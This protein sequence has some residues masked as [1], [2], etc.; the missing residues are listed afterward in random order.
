MQNEY[1]PNESYYFARVNKMS[2]AQLIREEKKVAN[3]ILRGSNVPQGLYRRIIELINKRKG[4][5][6][7]SD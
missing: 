6:N 3:D 1:G 4:E 5:L 7:G 2:L